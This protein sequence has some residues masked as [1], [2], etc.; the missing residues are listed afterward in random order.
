M[1]NRCQDKTLTSCLPCQERFT[2]CVGKP[3]GRNQVP[4]DMYSYVDCL[5]NRTI[6][7]IRCQHGLFF[8]PV[9]KQCIPLKFF[10]RFASRFFFILFVKF[11][12]YWHC[13]F[14][15]WYLSNRDWIAKILPI[16]RKTPTNQS[17]RYHTLEFKP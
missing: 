13:W 2:T 15:L 14:K 11:L 8:H 12:L 16:R 17:I 6:N 5:L 4:G 3:N 7:K 9:V 10:G 1:Q